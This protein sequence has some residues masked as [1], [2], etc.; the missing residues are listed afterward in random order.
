MDEL[1]QLCQTVQAYIF[2]LGP[3]PSN[4]NITLNLN[5]EDIANSLLF[6]LTKLSPRTL[7]VIENYKSSEFDPI[8]VDEFYEKFPVLQRQNTPQSSEESNSYRSE[9]DEYLEKMPDEHY[10]L[11]Y[12]LLN[13]FMLN[14]SDKEKLRN[15][16]DKKKEEITKLKEQADE[17]EHVPGFTEELLNLERMVISSKKLAI[18][19]EKYPK[20]K[21][22]KYLFRGMNYDKDEWLARYGRSSL[23][24]PTFFSTSLNLKVAYGF[25]NPAKPFILIIMMEGGNFHFPYISKCINRDNCEAEVL[26]PPDVELLYVCEFKMYSEN[27]VLY[28][29][30]KFDKLPDVYWSNLLDNLNTALITYSQTKYGWTDSKV[31]HIMHTHSRAANRSRTANRSRAKNHSKPIHSSHSMITRSHAAKHSSVIGNS[32]IISYNLSKSKGGF[33]KIRKIR[34]TR[35]RIKYNTL[36]KR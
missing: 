28:K 29:L 19:L 18:G 10:V 17:D 25:T 9:V 15:F 7:R 4:F 13:D 35:K 3:D 30:V 36:K 27:Y 33:K 5:D 24:T 12:S 26:L 16:F 11:Y 20:N 2:S 21:T 32:S 23:V 1:Q 31:S 6:M 14:S 22:N 34:K 8:E